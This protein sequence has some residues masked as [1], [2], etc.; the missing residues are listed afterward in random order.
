MKDQLYLVWQYIKHGKLKT[1]FTL[2]VFVMA[3]SLM[4][5]LIF[6]KTSNDTFIQQQETY[7]SGDY[8]LSV[9]VVNRS[10]IYIDEA[11]IE[12]SI[13]VYDYAVSPQ[14]NGSYILL[15]NVT[16]HTNIQGFR[17]WSGSFPKAEGDVLISR[18]YSKNHGLQLQDNFTIETGNRFLNQSNVNAETDYSNDE[19]YVKASSITLHVTGIYEPEITTNSVAIQDEMILYYPHIGNT[20]M[21]Y[22][23][24][25]PA[26]ADSWDQIKN[27]PLL[28]I[29]THGEDLL[30]H[31]APDNP[32]GTVLTFISFIT[33]VLLVLLISN[34]LS[35]TIKERSRQLGV[36]RTIGATKLQLVSFTMTEVFLYAVVAIP[37][38][39]GIAVGISLFLLKKM[40][41]LTSVSEWLPFTYRLVI[42]YRELAA[43][44]ILILFIAAAACLLALYPAIKA[45][46]ISLIKET[47]GNKKIKGKSYYFTEHLFGIEGMIGKCYHKQNKRG[48]FTTLMALTISFI[49]L[50]TGAITMR[51]LASSYQNE[52]DKVSVFFKNINT[53]DQYDTILKL[54]DQC[55]AD[56]NLE[57]YS[58]K[59]SLILNNIG[60][61]DDQFNT[62]ALAVINKG[63]LSLQI[64][65]L[66]NGTHLFNDN[67]QAILRDNVTV[68][69]E[70]GE[71]GVYSYFDSS[72]SEFTFQ[73]PYVRDRNSIFLSF[74]LIPDEISTVDMDTIQMNPTLYVSPQRMKTIIQEL[75][76]NKITDFTIAN[77]LLLQDQNSK[78]I[79]ID[80][81]EKQEQHNGWI[82]NVLQQDKNAVEAVTE[83]FTLVLSGITLMMIII[84]I[85]NLLCVAIHNVIS[86]KKEYAILLS[87]GIKR[88]QLLKLLLFENTLTLCKAYLLSIP[89]TIVVYSILFFQLFRTRAVFFLPWDF[90]FYSFLFVCILLLIIVLSSY[91]V[92][93]KCNIIQS[94]YED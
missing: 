50:F 57:D 53:A 56:N 6:L 74:T 91:Q 36:L 73:Y 88:K 49:L 51:M 48:K 64:V 41:E 61:S 44:C 52:A 39:I 24:L 17:I 81:K 86:K 20:G 27:N 31:S 4:A 7:G 21:E 60:V 82:M 85:I 37:I 14:T 45:T 9:D 22:I 42:D 89:F 55:I 94:I 3:V 76:Q 87:L 43:I 2:C 93:K 34:I 47:Q 5:S 70:K 30:L 84:S 8:Q 19:K 68:E 33:I 29:N 32:I 59:S 35:V 72:I 80:I 11:L 63:S 78:N 38:G 62:D 40:T 79:V 18:E 13:A 69:N 83:S 66:D 26:A 23:K 28:N 1:F 15:R 71:S 90:L 25:K 10:S 58:F 65:A 12:D 67:K 92:F 75:Q 16:E 77:S 46:P 54:K